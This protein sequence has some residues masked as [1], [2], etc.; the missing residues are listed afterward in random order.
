[1]SLSPTNFCHVPWLKNARR[2]A[3]V[4]RSAM[5]RGGIRIHRCFAYRKAS[6]ERFAF[7][8]PPGR[9]QGE[10]ACAICERGAEYDKVSRH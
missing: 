3:A 2:H 5:P 6:A 7:S 9:A 8:S 1:M 4:H 10:Y